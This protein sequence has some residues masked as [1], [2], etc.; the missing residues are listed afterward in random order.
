M[1]MQKAPDVNNGGDH[2]PCEKAG[3]TKQMSKSGCNSHR[4]RRWRQ[5]SSMT[6]VNHIVP[7][8][9]RWPKFSDSMETASKHGSACHP[10]TMTQQRYD[11][12]CIHRATLCGGVS[13]R[14]R[15]ARTHHPICVEHPRTGPRYERNTHA[16]CHRWNVGG[17][18]LH[19]APM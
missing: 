5:V 8:Q 6:H 18:C 12:A 1:I 3:A 2:K 14:R 13:R 9:D 10:R 15:E 16:E 19:R 4:S 17:C 7:G 11:E